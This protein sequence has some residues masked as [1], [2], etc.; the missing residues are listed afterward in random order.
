MKLP[1]EVRACT[2]A[3]VAAL[4][5]HKTGRPLAQSIV[6][7]LIL[8]TGVRVHLGRPEYSGKYLPLQGHHGMGQLSRA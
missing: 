5:R 3:C 1:G 6:C 8:C 4:Y 7:P 2:T